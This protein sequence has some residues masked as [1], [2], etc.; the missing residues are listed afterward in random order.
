MIEFNKKRNEEE[1]KKNKQ[2]KSA[3]ISLKVRLVN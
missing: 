2:I 3:P 1:E